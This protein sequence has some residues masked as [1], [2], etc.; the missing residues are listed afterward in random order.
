MKK[1]KIKIIILGFVIPVLI[2]IAWYLATNF[3]NTPE[4]ILPKISTVIES[5]GAMLQSGQLW[6]DLSVT[7]LRVVKGYLVSAVIGI[8]LGALMGMSKTIQH[9]L[10]P[11]IT[12]IRQIPIIAWIPLIILW[13]GIGE[14]SKVVVIVIAALFPILV[15]TMSGISSTPGGFIEVAKLYKL[16]YWR[17]FIKVYLP[18]ALPQIFVG[19][20]LGLSVSWMAVV[21]AE[22]IAASSG[23]GYRMS[24]A[25]S[26]MYSEQV[27]VCMIVIGVIGILMDKAIGLLFKKLTPWEK[28]S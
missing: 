15:N 18:H 7:L 17:T 14:E 9:L 12:V 20:K 26:L 10:Q 22:L 3:G 4:S 11:I 5:F 19:L 2:I 8:V 1:Q 16:N 6:D 28:K 25:R 24:T 21:A 13:F 23:I 27:I